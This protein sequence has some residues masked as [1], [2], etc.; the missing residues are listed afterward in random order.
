MRGYSREATRL[1]GI[2][3]LATGLLLLLLLGALLS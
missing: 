1:G 2:E 3:V